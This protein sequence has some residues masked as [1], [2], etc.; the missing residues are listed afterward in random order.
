MERSGNSPTVTK[1]NGTGV[2][3]ADPLWKNAPERAEYLT[4]EFA[5]VADGFAVQDVVNAT[6]GLMVTALR[7]SYATKQEAEIRYDEI[8][9]RMKSILLSHYDSIS[10]RQKGV[11]PYDQHVYPDL[12]KSNGKIITN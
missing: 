12:V 2:N 9:G 1:L 10:G 3:P 5:R 11:F 4:K 7:Q 6:A 8:F